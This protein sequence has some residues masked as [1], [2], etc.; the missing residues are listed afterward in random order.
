VLATTVGNDL[1]NEVTTRIW[2]KGRGGDISD[3]F[4][5]TEPVTKEVKYE[6]N[7]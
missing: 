2:K 7:N 4:W 5:K 3:R 1:I 6:D